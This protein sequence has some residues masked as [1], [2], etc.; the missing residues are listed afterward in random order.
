M[1]F[2]SLPGAISPH[3]LVVWF[4]WQAVPEPRETPWTWTERQALAGAGVVIPDEGLRRA[5][6]LR[7]WKTLLASVR[8]QLVLARPRFHH[9]EVVRPHPLQARLQALSTG[10]LRVRDVEPS[11]GGD[12]VPYG[13]RTVQH[14]VRTLPA[15]R[16]WWRLGRE[17]AARPQESFTSLSQWIYRPHQ[18]LLRYAAR[19]KPGPLSELRIQANVQAG[20]ILDRIASDLFSG[21]PAHWRDVPDEVIERW[22]SSRWDPV[23]RE[24]ALNLLQ[25]GQRVVAESLRETAR[26][27]LLN[28]ARLFRQAGV[29]SVVAQ[30]SLVPIA[31]EG[32][33]LAGI[34]DLICRR[35][36]DNRVGILDL[37]L[38]GSQVR[39]REVAESRALQLAIYRR[40]YLAANPLAEPP[41]TG[42]FILG[43]QRLLTAHA[44]WGEPTVV[45]EANADERCWQ[46]FLQMWR[47][48]RDQ[49][50]SGWV[51]VVSPDAMET[52]GP[53][54]AAVP[55]VPTWCAEDSGASRDPYLNLSGWNPLA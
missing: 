51:E 44:F 48:R 54:S 12:G 40:L 29:D 2:V 11:K 52:D 26:R 45:T 13:Q 41:D 3:D 9:G 43:A 23:L 38:G 37:K 7:G 55:P 21:D 16:R 17:V 25:P 35:N 46:D 14:P 28:L 36:A 6:E 39:E 27:V 34:P 10:T 53:L 33:S 42:F 19:L 49:L 47:W 32:I 50:V 22:L 24:M 4:G 18:W 1:T 15:I 30:A 20:S 8:G 5:R 31:F